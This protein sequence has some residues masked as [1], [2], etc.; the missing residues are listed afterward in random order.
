V[1]KALL[2][3]SGWP[4]VLETTSARRALLTTT[5]VDVEFAVAVSTEAGLVAAPA[6]CLFILYR[7]TRA[8]APHPPPARGHSFHFQ[9]IFILFFQRSSRF[10]A[11][12]MVS[13][14]NLI[15]GLFAHNA[16]M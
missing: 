5:R 9:L 2:A 13:S 16:R 8:H 3:R 11:L 14:T 10:K 6:H 12:H 15:V 1:P 7:C 4:Y